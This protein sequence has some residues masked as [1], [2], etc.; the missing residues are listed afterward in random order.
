MFEDGEDGVQEFAHDGD[1]G[2]HFGFAT[3]QETLI[4]AAQVRIAGGA[5]IA[6]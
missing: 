4:E 6:V 5:D 2:L 3:R 1:E